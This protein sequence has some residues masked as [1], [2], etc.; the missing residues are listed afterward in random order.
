MENIYGKRRRW[1]QTSIFGSVGWELK[2][3]NAGIFYIGGSY[4][5]HFKD[6][7]FLLPGG[8]NR[9]TDGRDVPFHA[10]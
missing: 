10:P 8:G 2:S 5:V 3:R 9:Y 6:M 4:Q 7:F 1:I